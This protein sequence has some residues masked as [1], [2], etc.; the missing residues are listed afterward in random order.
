[1]EFCAETGRRQELQAKPQF[2]SAG[3]GVESKLKDLRDLRSERGR[4]VLVAP[5]CSKVAHSSFQLRELN[6][7]E[8][9]GK[10]FRTSAFASHHSAQLPMKGLPNLGTIFG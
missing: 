4:A 10:Q 5:P 9:G 3:V 8:S 7:P 1:M 6:G 2:S